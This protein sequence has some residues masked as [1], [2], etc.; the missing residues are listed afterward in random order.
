MLKSNRRPAALNPP[1]SR[2]RHGKTIA[3]KYGKIGEN[4]TAEKKLVWAQLRPFLSI[5]V[6]S[7]ANRT[8]K[9]ALDAYANRQKV[10]PNTRER[11]KTAIT[12]L[13]RL[14]AKRMIEVRP[15]DIE[16]ALDSINSNRGKP[17]A[18][19][20]QMVYKLLRV[21]FEK[22]LND[23]LITRNPSKRSM[24]HNTIA[25]RKHAFSRR[26]NKASSEKLT[27]S[28]AVRTTR[29]FGFA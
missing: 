9:E 6:G 25:K 24:R 3:R 28:A 13:D 23:G 8:V 12:Y 18:R 2:T 17:M 11:Y 19:T 22:A 15:S 16:N 29:R 5:A 1:G 10:R 7:N 26:S 4:S 21:I 27:S 14:G 20:R